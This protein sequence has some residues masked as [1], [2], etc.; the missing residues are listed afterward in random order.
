[1][2]EKSQVE[3]LNCQ[4]RI[5]T[6]FMSVFLKEHS[7]HSAKNGELK[8]RRCV[9]GDWFL[10]IPEGESY[11]GNYLEKMWRSVLKSRVKQIKPNRILILGSGAGCAVYVAGKLWPTS[12]I[13]AVDYDPAIVEIGKQIY[14]FE[15]FNVR[16]IVSDAADFVKGC[17]KNY[18]LI[19]VDLFLK[20]KPSPLLKNENFVS[21]ICWIL[22]K[23]AM[24]V[25]NFATKLSGCDREIIQTWNKI[26]LESEHLSYYSNRLFV[27]ATSEIPRDY[28]DIFQSQPWSQMARKKGL[29][30]AGKERAYLYIRQLP[31]GLG[32]VS[33][34]HT[35]QDPDLGLI[36]DLGCRRGIIF[37]SQ[38]ERRLAPRPWKRCLL[39]FH[40]K[41]NGLA[42]VGP[43]YRQKWSQMARRNLKK[44][45]AALVDIQI[46]PAETFIGGLRPS[47]LKPSL[48]EGFI[49]MINNIDRGSLE[50]IVAQKDG[51]IVGGLALVNYAN[52]SAHFVAYLTQDG[53][54][55]QA[56]VG[57]MDWWY[58]YALARQIKYLN[59]GNIRQKWE[60]RSWQGYSD[61]KRKFIDKEIRLTNGWWR[62]FGRY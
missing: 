46:V 23:P 15:K 56:G 11:S 42:I 31:F 21:H 51:N 27:A 34:T 53:Q 20:N 3:N 22:K 54:V 13:D 6:R 2:S 10:K 1:M 33:A 48:Q 40:Q 49:S 25:V 30:V 61:F 59:F 18:D 44:F 29:S 8:L 60:P 50:F 14:N 41:G 36:R 52:I 17:D 55:L 16:F 19:I 47:T 5:S 24:A 9:W 39:P 28:Y 32:I 37:W 57:L 12:L 45:Q 58:E 38:W 35:D 43:D 4:R 62:F 7:F 26:F